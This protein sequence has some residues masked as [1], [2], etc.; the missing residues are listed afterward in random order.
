S[1]ARHDRLGLPCNVRQARRGPHHGLA[2][3]SRRDAFA[4]LCPHSNSGPCMRAHASVIL[5]VALL[6]AG[7][8]TAPTSQSGATI[9]NV[10]SASTT[11]TADDNLNA[12]LWVQRSAEY[13]ANTI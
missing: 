6:A 8:A 13:Q 9:G 2:A 11:V 4:T 3:G 7:C 1:A 5:F 12:V 10:A